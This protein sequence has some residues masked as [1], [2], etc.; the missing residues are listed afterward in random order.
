MVVA[1]R[2]TITL[3]ELLALPIDLDAVIAGFAL[4]LDE[5]FGALRIR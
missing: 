4:C 5:L 2:R 1:R 3:A